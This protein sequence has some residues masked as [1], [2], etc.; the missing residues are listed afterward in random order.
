MRNM[1]MK[2]RRKPPAQFAVCIKDKGY[3]AS[4]EIGRFRNTPILGDE[5]S[6]WSP[7]QSNATALLP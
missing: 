7:K 3:E 6:W 5:S 2:K 4:L 1:R